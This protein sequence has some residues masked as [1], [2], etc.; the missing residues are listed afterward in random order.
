MDDNKGQARQ[1]TFSRSRGLT[2]FTRLP[3]ETVRKG[4]R[5]ASGASILALKAAKEGSFE[6]FRRLLSLQF[7]AD[8]GFS[9]SFIGSLLGNQA[10]GEE[11]S[12]ELGKDDAQVRSRRRQ[13][14]V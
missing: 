2:L 9:D 5:V 7:R 3:I 12:S 8:H 10:A 11:R 6:P 4:S 1:R 13:E 14:R